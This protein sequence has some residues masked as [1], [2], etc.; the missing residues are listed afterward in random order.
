MRKRRFRLGRTVLLLL[1][2]GGAAV[3]LRQGLIPSKFVPLPT[4]SLDHPTALL[5]DW[6]IAALR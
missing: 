5:I 3:A 4:V 2:L 6:R 1:L